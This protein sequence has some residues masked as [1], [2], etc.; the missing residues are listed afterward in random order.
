MER[1]GLIYNNK[2]QCFEKIRKRLTSNPNFIILGEAQNAS[3][4][5]DGIPKRAIFDYLLIEAPIK[6]NEEICS[7]LKQLRK[8]QINTEI[9]LFGPDCSVKTIL[10]LLKSGI[11]GYFISDYG[12]G[13]FLIC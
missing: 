13:Y 11:S 9:I 7:H 10:T 8:K 12:E 4:F 5:L 2:S 3:T 6:C 1:F